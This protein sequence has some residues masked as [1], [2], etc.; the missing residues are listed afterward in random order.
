MGFESHESQT[1]CVVEEASTFLFDSTVT[2][3]RKRRFF[4]KL[5]FSPASSRVLNLSHQGVLKRAGARPVYCSSLCWFDGAANED[6]DCDFTDLL[7]RLSDEQ[8]LSKIVRRGLARSRSFPPEGW[9]T[10]KYVLQI[11]KMGRPSLERG[12]RSRGTAV[13]EKSSQAADTTSV[14]C[15]TDVKHGTSKAVG[16]SY[17]PSTQ[18]SSSVDQASSPDNMSIDSAPHDKDNSVGMVDD[19]HQAGRNATAKAVTEGVSSA[20][21]TALLRNVERCLSIPLAQTHL[22]VKQ[23]CVKDSIPSGKVLICGRRREMEDTA[24]IVSSFM[25]VPRGKMMDGQ[26]IDLHFYGVYDGH[27]GS[28]V[29]QNLIFGP[30]LANI[31]LG[32]CA[33][34][35]AGW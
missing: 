14:S 26:M 11:S 18:A 8:G 31:E 16:F 33:S 25:Q 2:A 23:G 1:A 30:N 29:R 19:Q 21:K 5:P 28:Q 17:S 6:D 4:K 32:F 24:V 20:G 13:K 35:F 12:G 22:E 3:R 15:I 9:Q 27:G 7:V 10:S 34:N